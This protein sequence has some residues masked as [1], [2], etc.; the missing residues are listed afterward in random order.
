ML[1]SFPLVKVNVNTI[2]ELGYSARDKIHE[3][4]A[5][6]CVLVQPVCFGLLIFQ[7]HSCVNDGSHLCSGW[8]RVIFTSVSESCAYLLKFLLEQHL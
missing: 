7:T 4:I 1:S 2:S 8:L 3:S 5:M 6:P